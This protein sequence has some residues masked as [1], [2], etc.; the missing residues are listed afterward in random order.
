M[1]WTIRPLADWSSRMRGS[2]RQY[3]Q[4]TDSALANNFVTVTAKVVAAMAHEYEL[5]LGYLTR[6]MFLT[7]AT[8]KWLAAHCYEVGIFRKP[9]ARAS[10]VIA[11]V[12]AVSTTYPAGIRFQSG[13][14]IYVST[15]AV[16][17][18][19]S[20]AVEFSV[21]AQSAGLA[22]NRDA[23]SELALAD[24][25]LYPAL[26]DTF[27]V[28]SGGLGGGADTEL[29]TGLRARGLQRKQNPPGGGT[30]T[31]YERY[32]L[33][34]PGVLKAWA[35]QMST[36]GSLVVLFLFEGR[37]DYIP[38][39]ADVAVVQA[40]IDAQRLIRVDNSVAAAAVAREIDIEIG[41]LSQDTPEIR[42]TIEQ[43][44]TDM[45]L[46]KCRPGIAASTFTVSVSW[47]AEAISQASGEERHRLIAPLA[48]ITLTNGE[49][50]VLGEVT[51][52]A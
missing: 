43:A 30:L 23:G 51:Y 6:Q 52:G 1:P 24:A 49:F 47:I 26:S 35:F 15:A 19:A 8:G 7:T 31:D 45:F 11:G 41:G 14:I 28:A 33:E 44:I 21:R 37:D 27:T 48:D 17:S 3:L 40:A 10:G 20:G 12:G 22:G 18:S 25:G 42:A 50:P 4:G 36:P 2:F 32:A 38:L 39:P 34:V 16:T 29:D 13:N 9:A 46:E 5:R